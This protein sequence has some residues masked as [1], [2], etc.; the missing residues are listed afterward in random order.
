[1]L[2]TMCQTVFLLSTLMKTVNHD[3]L[4]C[5]VCVAWNKPSSCLS[6]T[7]HQVQHLHMQIQISPRVWL[8]GCSCVLQNVLFGTQQLLQKASH[9]WISGSHIT[10]LQ[11]YNAK[12]ESCIHRVAQQCAAPSQEHGLLL[13]SKAAA[14]MAT[15]VDVFLHRVQC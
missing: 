8:S 9:Q 12:I 13:S 6:G 15:N 14:I 10:G 11:H 1:M 2:L 7:R 5:P 4:P 3:R